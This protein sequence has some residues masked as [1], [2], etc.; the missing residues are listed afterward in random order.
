[1]KLIECLAA[2]LVATTAAAQPAPPA[3]IQ[4]APRQPAAPAESKARNATLQSL[5][6]LEGCW[7]GTAGGREFREQWMPLRGE[8]MLGVSQTLDEKGATQDYE[9]LR[10]ELRDGAV[11]YVAARSGKSEIALKFEAETTY[12][13]N[14]RNDTVFTF[15]NRA[16]EFPRLISYRRATEGWLYASVEGKVA[17]AERKATYPMRRIDCETG[18]VVGR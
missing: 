5:A 14:D 17:G 6:W 3:P 4:T 11:H 2:A 16:Q 1:M 10:L 15:L 7:R 8:M 9:Y 18:E 13:A 12:T